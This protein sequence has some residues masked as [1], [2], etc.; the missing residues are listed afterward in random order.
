LEGATSFAA[1]VP[2][3]SD[4]IATSFRIFMLG[5]IELS[6]GET[7]KLFLP[8][9]GTNFSRQN[10]A[11]PPRTLANFTEAPAFFAADKG[12]VSRLKLIWATRA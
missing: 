12:G 10:P 11:N 4:E 7:D 2:Q 6:V 5:K 1:R 3:T 8:I 9:P